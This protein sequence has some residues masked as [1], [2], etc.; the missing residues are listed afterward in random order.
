MKYLITIIVTLFLLSH[1]IYAQIDKYNYIVSYKYTFQKDKTD[2][3]STDYEDMILLINDEKSYFMSRTTFQK[4]TLF[5][6]HRPSSIAEAMEARKKFPKNR[7]KFE[8]EKNKVDNIN[9]YYEKVFTTTFRAKYKKDIIS[10][11]LI[12]EKRT[13]NGYVCRKAETSFAGRNYKAWYAEELPISD[14][15]YKFQGL[16]GLIL[17][18]TDDKKEHSFIMNG[19]EKKPIE[20][21]PSHK[22]VVEANMKEIQAGRANLM[23]NIKNSGFNVSPEMMQIAKEN[24]TKAN[25]HIEIIN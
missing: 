5:T 19:L 1:E 22:N 11:K 23:N 3:N 15:P 6:K 17:E 8:I 16:P 21:A 2:L 25:N 10:W 9:S 24:L 7:V 20:Y 13:I 14:G 12:N 18:V 4:D